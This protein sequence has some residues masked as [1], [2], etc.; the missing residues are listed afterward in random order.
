MGLMGKVAVGQWTRIVIGM[1]LSNSA[2]IGWVE[3]YVNGVNTVAHT[4]V[5]TMDS[6]SDGSPDPIYLKQGIYRS[7]DWDTIGATHVFYYGNVLI[8]STLVSVE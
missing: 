6:L 4:S 3:A 8:G 1:K 2:S 7:S 5:A